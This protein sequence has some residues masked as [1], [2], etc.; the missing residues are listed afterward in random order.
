MDTKPNTVA[1]YIGSFPKETQAI[2]EKLRNTISTTVTHCTE[3][4]SYGMPAYKTYNKPLVYFAAY[5]KHIGLYATPTAHEYF[6]KELAKYKKGKGSVQFPINE[7]MPW[8]LIKKMV[9]F[10]DTENKK[11]QKKLT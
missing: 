10:K 3:S 7:E 2:L 9:L 1:E 6:A 5:T 11:S 4:I 8:N